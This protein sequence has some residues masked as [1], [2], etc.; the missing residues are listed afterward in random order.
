MEYKFYLDKAEKS[1]KTV[2]GQVN[3]ES[4]SSWQDDAVSW[5]TRSLPFKPDSVKGIKIDWWLLKWPEKDSK[6]FE[7]TSYINT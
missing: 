2:S 5:D 6:E 4:W 1:K 3:L 7:L